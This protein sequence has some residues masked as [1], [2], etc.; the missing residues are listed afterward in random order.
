MK[1]KKRKTG[2]FQRFQTFTMNR[3]M[4]SSVMEKNS[5]T[6]WRA[7]ILFA[8]LF[9]G[10]L[11]FSIALVPIFIMIIKERIWG[12]AI[13]DGTALIISINLLLSRRLEYETR[14]AITLLITYAVGLAVIII[15]GPMSG[16]P[17]WLF[18]FA[19]L[20]G[21][22]L[23]SKAAIMAL[24][25]NTI[26][27]TI[28]GW[29]IITAR[30]GSTFP[31]FNTFEA[32][33]AAGAN[34][35][36]LNAVAAISVSI[37]VKGLAETHQKERDLNSALESERLNLIEEKKKLEVEIEGRMQV[38][39]ALQDSEKRY[40][41]LADS[42]P[43][44]VFETD[45]KGNLTFTNRNAFDLFGYTRSDFKEG[46]SAIQMLVPE[47]RNIAINY[48]QK[49][50]NGESMGGIEYT[51]QRKDGS[52]FPV[53]IHSNPIIR[54]NKTMGMSGIIIDLTTLKQAELALQHSEERYRSLV[55]NTIYGYFIFEIPSGRFLF[56][57]QRSCDLYG[58][59]MQEGLELSI[60]DV[61]SPEDHED[62]RKLIKEQLE[63]KRLSSEHR[64]YNAVRKDGSTFRIEIYTSF[65]TFKDKPVI[66]GVLRDVTEQERLEHQLQQSQRMKAIGTLA[67]GIAHDFNNL[68]MGIQGYASLML[69]D[70]D[71]SHPHHEKLKNIEQYVQN[72][73]ELTK[74]LLGF[75]MGGKY[76]VKPTDINELIKKNSR[77]FGRTR[78]EVRFHEKYQKNL[79][80]V[81]V[82]QGQMEQIFL[83]LYINAWQAMPGGGELYLKTENVIL[84][85]NYVKSHD[86]EPGRY[87]KISV[88]DTGTGMDEDTKQRIFDPFFTTKEMG[89]GTGLGLASAYGIIKN[90]GGFINVY[91]EQGQGTTFNIYFPVSEKGLSGEKGFAEEVL[92]GTE[93]VLF[94]DDEDIII[95]VGEQLLEKLGYSVLKAKNGRDALDIYKEKR[96]IIDIVVLDMIMPEMNGGDVYDRL[97]ESNPEIKVIL[98]SG[99][100]VNGLAQDI[101]DRG[102]NG[103]IQKPFNLKELSHKLREI[104]DKK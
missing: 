18:T 102:C 79:W 53:V 96:D 9:G 89:R 68:L 37:L 76:E 49:V 62:I 19:V 61:M 4:P 20:A 65:I 32:M 16:G 67:G 92:R 73:S 15:V 5:L 81:E 17:A 94:V 93:M 45:E 23:G 22:F 1:T 34:F 50:L 84:D 75:A 14:A 95:D 30:F 3:M 48:M 36:A 104:L 101:L 35:I 98:S 11:I 87:I 21:V 70:L 8:I 72:G 91:S 88:T 33:I 41:K 64:I 38:E 99:Y 42:L 2:Y 82:D 6:F 52:T 83:N 12:L 78:K 54:E 63:H 74:Q 47:D 44:I 56:L 59:P 27:L 31:F 90:H 71:T 85:E 7:R 97:K 57:N 66:Q 86:V 10:L 13:I 26:T 60:W 28:I 69:L 25:I 77:I 100:S 40:R 58:Y 55:E 80:T 39:K 29:L 24:T 43:Q 103:F 46:L 51:A